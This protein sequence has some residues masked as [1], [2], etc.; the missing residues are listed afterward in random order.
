MTADMVWC[1][2]ALLS[3][4]GASA[5]SAIKAATSAAARLLGVDA[6]TGTIEDGKLPTS[7]SSRAIRC[8]TSRRS[9]DRSP[10]GR[11]AARSAPERSLSV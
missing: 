1:E 10:S 4:H 6:A 5:M 9:D 11:V 2:I 3:D 8:R 7:C